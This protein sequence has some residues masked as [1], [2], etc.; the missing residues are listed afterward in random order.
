MKYFTLLLL[1]NFISSLASAATYKLFDPEMSV[2]LYYVERGNLYVG[3]MRVMPGDELV[4][5]TGE[6][7]Y[8]QRYLGSGSNTIVILDESFAAI[9]L[10]QLNDRLAMNVFVGFFETQMFLKTHLQEENL[11]QILDYQHQSMHAIRVEWL[12]IEDNLLDYLHSH[13]DKT[14][15]KFKQLIDFLH[16]FKGISFLGDFTPEQVGYVYGRGWVIFDFGTRIG[17]DKSAP[18]TQVIDQHDF[19][20]AIPHDVFELL[21]H[22][23]II[24]DMNVHDLTYTTA[25]SCMVFLN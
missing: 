20:G 8:F 23:L 3:K 13:F 18:A 22:E 21:N 24:K 2:P 9:R 6:V 12:P 15:L 16:Q 25:A 14:Q 4:L 10:T 11:V 7:I 1:I 5:D 17:F 19:R